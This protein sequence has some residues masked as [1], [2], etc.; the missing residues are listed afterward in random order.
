MKKLLLLSFLCIIACKEI[1]YKEPQ[2]KGIKV[3]P[4]VPKNLIGKYPLPED[5]G[6]VK[7]SLVVHATG[8]FF[9]NDDDKGVLSENLILKYYK[10]YYFINIKNDPEWILRIIRQEKDGSI[11]LM[12]MET[13]EAKFTSLVTQLSQEVKVDTIV[14]AEETFYEIDPSPKEMMGLIKKGFFKKSS[15]LKKVKQ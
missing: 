14:I 1:T 7:D 12:S 15:V 10:G 6:T 3:L 4:A 2:P 9:T 13:D 5:D 11:S 8:Y